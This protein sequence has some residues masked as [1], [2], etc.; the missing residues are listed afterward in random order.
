MALVLFTRLAAGGMLLVAGCALFAPMAAQ[1]QPSGQ[2]STFCCDV[3]GQPVCGDILQPVCYNRAYR[4]ITPQG[5]TRLFVAAPLTPEEVAKRDEEARLQREAAAQ[6]LKQRR[7][8][9][10]LLE[11]YPTISSIDDRRDREVAGLDTRLAEL[12]IRETELVERRKT[13]DETIRALNG[14]PMSADMEEAVRNIDGEINSLRLVI[15]AKV[16]E[17]SGV[18]AR[19]DEERRRY[20]DLT[21]PG[22]RSSN[23]R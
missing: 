13:L 20:L 18:R 6:A 15:E 12:R 7:L 21:S 10:A 14:K 23:S 2:R 16:R 5:R 22:V 11:A 17:R 3:G 8:D 4:E 19:F 9:H 1:A